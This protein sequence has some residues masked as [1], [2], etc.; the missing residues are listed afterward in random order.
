MRFPLMIASAALLCSCSGPPEEVGT[1]I[2][3]SPGNGANS[4]Q[5]PPAN[6]SQ[7]GTTS[8]PSDNREYWLG[9]YKTVINDGGFECPSVTSY[10]TLRGSGSM[11]AVCSNG[12]RF[13]VVTL[14][15]GEVRQAFRCSD[16][17]ADSDYCG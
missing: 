13:H 6:S 3:R 8:P 12:D 17:P 14:K 11:L 10:R 7:A 15:P 2:E 16:D 1:D 4:Q 9:L 5:P